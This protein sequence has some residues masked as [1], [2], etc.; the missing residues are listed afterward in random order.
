MQM[1]DAS[2]PFDLIISAASF[3]SAPLARAATESFGWSGNP[4]ECGI[5]SLDAAYCAKEL[6]EKMRGRRVLFVGTCGVFGRFLE[7]SLVRVTTVLWM[8]S[9][10]R[11][12]KAYRVQGTS[13]E[14]DLSTR[15]STVFRD[16][17][18]SVCLCGPSIS[19]DS[20]VSPALVASQ[21]NTDALFTENLELYPIAFW[22]LQA[23]KTFDALLV[24]TNQV[25]IDAHR[26]WRRNFQEAANLTRDR[27]M[28]ALKL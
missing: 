24:S 27:V 28:G 3:E 14:I 23:C 17:P 12:G 8:P 9:A 25:G 1:A 10:E 18:S 22:A 7:P 6:S 4:V 19:L 20:G 11:V 5:G 15:G 26:D 2:F 16:L 21:G 13:P